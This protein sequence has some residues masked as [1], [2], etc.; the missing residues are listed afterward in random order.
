LSWVNL[1]QPFY[2][3]MP[4][5]DSFPI[6]QIKK[7]HKLEKDR[8]NVTEYKFT[9]H[10]GTHVDAPSHFI[11]NGPNID[12]L[13]LDSFMGEGVVIALRKKPLSLI[14]K[15]D[16]LNHQNLI[17]ENDI[18]I[19]HTGWDQ[20]YGDESYHDHPYLAS[21][22]AEWLVSKKIKALG[23]DFTTPDYPIKLR[24]EEFNWP[25]HHIL[26]KNNILII[27][28]LANLSSLDNQRV[29][30]NAAPIMIKGADGAPARVIAKKH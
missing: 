22:V 4:Y 20:R 2:N 17:K 1:S 3:G 14:T 28:H 10:I 7:L 19:L 24:S 5:P 15:E 23:V 9:T 18:V 16:L 13:P 25:I 12:D 11:K 29:F 30:I 8:V 21:E 27:E 6:P 26:L